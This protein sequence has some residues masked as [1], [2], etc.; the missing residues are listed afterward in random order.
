MKRRYRGFFETDLDILLREL[1]VDTVILTDIYIRVM[2]TA[3][4]AFFKVIT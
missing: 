4:D 3:A 2:H 1:G